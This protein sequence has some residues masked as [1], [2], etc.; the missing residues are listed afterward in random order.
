M[1]VRLTTELLQRFSVHGG[2]WR[3]LHEALAAVD[4]LLAFAAFAASAEG[5]TCHPVLLPEGA[6]DGAGLN[7]LGFCVT[8]KA[9]EEAPPPHSPS[10]PKAT[11]AAP[12]LLFEGA[13]A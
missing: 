9:R 3:A 4:V 5:D 13:D 1:Q 8:G 11:P 7:L 6:A 2:A 10:R 12:L